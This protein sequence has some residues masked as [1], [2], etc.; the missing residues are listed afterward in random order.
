LMAIAGWGGALYYVGYL[1]FGGKGVIPDG[2]LAL[3]LATLGL[4]MTGAMMLLWRRDRQF[5]SILL[6]GFYL[7]LLLF[8]SSS[9]WVW[10]LGEDYSVKPVA[11]MI[12]S[13][14]LISSDSLVPSGSS[15]P[16]TSPVARP[17]IL[18]SHPYHRPSLDFYSGYK[19]QPTDAEA[20]KQRWRQPS[21]V[22]LLQKNDVIALDL[23]RVQQLGQADDWILVRRKSKTR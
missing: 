4:T 17:Q 13:A 5:I 15:V 20:M 9:H 19:I 16:S 21:T 2:L 10:E 6:W 23:K 8:M 12:R 22:L 7:C 3:T 11:S 1:H 18:T 14:P